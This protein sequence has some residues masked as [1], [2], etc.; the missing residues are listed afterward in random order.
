MRILDREDFRIGVGD[1]NGPATGGAQARK[2]SARLRQPLDLVTNGALQGHDVERQRLAP[3]IDAIPVERALRRLEDGAHQAPRLVERHV[4][5]LGVAPRQ[6][7]FPEMHVPAE[8]KQRAVHV[9]QDGV[10]RS[11]VREMGASLHAP[12]I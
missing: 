2:E 9:E 1:E 5:A 11:P 3:E 10:D 7:L 12:M 6:E 4:P 8:I